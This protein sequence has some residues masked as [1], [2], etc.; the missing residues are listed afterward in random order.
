MWLTWRVLVQDNTW[1]LPQLADKRN[2]YWNDTSVRLVNGEPMAAGE[3]SWLPASVPASSPVQPVTHRIEFP[4]G[5][6]VVVQP[7]L[8]GD[9]PKPAHALR[10]AVVLDRSRSMAQHAN[11][12]QA[13]LAKLAETADTDPAI[14]VYLTASAYRGEKPA[15]VTLAQLDIDNIMYYGGQNAAELLV[16][17][18]SLHNG[19]T[20]DAIF[21]LT[22]GTGYE[23]DDSDLDVSVPA[24]PV[25][26]VHL[27]GHFPLGYDDAT[28]EAIQAS[29]GG[30]AGSVEEALTRLRVA[31]ADHL[32][33]PASV[34][35]TD[36]IDGYVWLTLP[37][38][39]AQVEP[40]EAVIHAPGDDFAAFAARRLILATMQRYRAGLDQLDNLDHLHEIAIKHSI[41][42][43][44]SSMIVL[45]N[46]QQEK[47]LDAL[48]TRDDRFQRE[49]EDVG[50][51]IPE[52]MLI[53]GVPEP[54]D[55][56]LLALVVGMLGWFIY[57]KRRTGQQY[58]MG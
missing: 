27:D 17:F 9:L 40:G 28:L 29:G 56:L 52:N 36:I 53:T 15:R 3:K 24:A 46:Q 38:G 30:V 54:E 57:T 50:E 43:P 42:T 19:Q 12:V 2:V 55:W 41:V 13:A 31:L 7:V 35:M 14:E 1:L 4:G 8:S 20:Y 6:T 10:L 44:Y 47:L 37:P 25:W 48:E 34:A 5:E 16:Q 22:D 18:D 32:A 23:L 49:Y 51:T 33:D 39:A 21:V 26:M 11:E 45:V 58:R